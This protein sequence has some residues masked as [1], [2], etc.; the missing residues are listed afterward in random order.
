LP[1][2]FTA[3][4]IVSTFAITSLPSQFPLTSFPISQ[5]FTVGP[6]VLKYSWMRAWT[7]AKLVPFMALES[8]ARP[9]TSAAADIADTDG[10]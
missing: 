10:R 2:A 5:I 1:A 3:S 4:Y 7:V 8:T 9:M 6:N